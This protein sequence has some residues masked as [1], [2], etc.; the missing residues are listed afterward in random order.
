MVILSKNPTPLQRFVVQQSYVES[1]RI[2]FLYD[3]DG[4]TVYVETYDG[5]ITLKQKFASQ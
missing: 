5:W 3:A 2:N 4:V 1:E